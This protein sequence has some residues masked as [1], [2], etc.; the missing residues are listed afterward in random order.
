ML[1]TGGGQGKP[2]VPSL[3]DYVTR[4]R[5]LLVEGRLGLRAAAES[6]SGGNSTNNNNDNSRNSIHGIRLVGV[7]Q[8]KT[9]FFR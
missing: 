2:T 1:D 5:P 4:T 3:Q 7:F 6:T 9:V 8:M